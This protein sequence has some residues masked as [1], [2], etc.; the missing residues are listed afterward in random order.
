[1]ISPLLILTAALCAEPPLIQPPPINVEA[2]TK[3]LLEMTKPSPGE[4]VLMLYDPTYYPEIT[5]RLEEELLKRGLFVAKFSEVGRP[6]LVWLNS[7]DRAK[8]LAQ[9]DAAVRLQGPMFQRADIFYWMPLRDYTDDM[10]YERLLRDSKARSVH[11]HWMLP[12]PGNRNAEQ[13]EADTR[14]TERAALEVDFARLHAFQEKLAEAMRGHEV[15]ITSPN[16][17]SL[18]VWVPRDQWFHFGDGDASLEKA[19]RARS[20]R[21]RE[22]ELGPGIFAFVPV[23]TRVEGVLKEPRVRQAEGVRIGLRRGR[24]AKLEAEK[25]LKELQDRFKI[26]GPDGDVIG[27]VSFATNPF[28]DPNLSIRLGE[29]WEMGGKNR[30][31]RGTW[32][33]VDRATVKVG[34]RVL[35]QDGKF[36]IQY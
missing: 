1:V 26:Q 32:V 36:V 23:A 16:G 9:E 11:F 25:G 34:D 18:R 27:V 14:R 6:G 30:A 22:I 29:N 20:T 15:T 8:Q 33:N 5:H 35:M 3:R 10:R 28:R 31:V 7:L 4:R 17:T 2:L 24:I 12:F 13:I 19:R 21:D